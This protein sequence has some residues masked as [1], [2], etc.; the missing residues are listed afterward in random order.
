MTGPR[1]T[2]HDVKGGGK[3]GC[4]MRLGERGVLDGA[5]GQSR[6]SGL[7][8]QLVVRGDA[9]LQAGTP[10]GRLRPG[11]TSRSAFLW[12]AR[13]EGLSLLV[14]VGL[15]VPLKYGA[16]MTEATIV[17]GW[18][19]GVLFVAYVVALGMVGRHEAWG[20]GRL[21]I[22]FLAAWLPFGTM[23]FEWWLSRAAPQ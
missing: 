22:A 14:L 2:Q 1:A 10:K 19:H 12:I 3:H 15:A 11:M 16:G 23:A 9:D 5:V 21:S 13:L 20:F 6:G 18:I 17:P 4:T 7:S 8:R